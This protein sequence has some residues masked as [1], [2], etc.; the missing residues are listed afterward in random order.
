MSRSSWTIG[1]EG[2]GQGCSGTMKRGKVVEVRVQ[3]MNGSNYDQKVRAFDGLT[4]ADE[5]RLT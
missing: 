4:I 3:V 1:S 5:V 2:K